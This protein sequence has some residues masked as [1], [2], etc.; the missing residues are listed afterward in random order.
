[1]KTKLNFSSIF[2][3]YFLIT[4]Y[5]CTINSQ[6]YTEESNPADFRIKNVNHIYHHATMVEKIKDSEITYFL[7]Y[8]HPDSENSKQGIKFLR[9]IVPKLEYLAEILLVNCQLSDYAER[10]VCIKPS[11]VKDGFPRMVVLIPPKVKINPYTKKPNSYVEKKYTEQEV[12]PKSIY[13][14]ITDNIPDFSIHL[15]N[16]N[17]DEFLNDYEY[18][19][20]ILF[21]DKETT[22]LLYRGLSGYYYDRVKFG[23]VKSDQKDINSRFQ[24]RQ[25][26]T[27]L[28]YNVID[29]GLILFNPS[30]DIYNGSTEAKSLVEAL[31]YT[32]LSEKKYIK[33]K[34]NE[35]KEEP[36]TDKPEAAKK[37]F[38]IKNLSSELIE[39]YISRSLS[40]PMIIIL[41]NKK[42]VN[43][44]VVEFAKKIAGFVAFLN[45]DCQD[46]ST[47]EFVE[48]KMKAKC[49]EGNKNH[50][51]YFLSDEVE[52]KEIKVEEVLKKSRQLEKYSYKELE[53]LMI[54]K[55]NS[56]VREIISQDYDSAKREVV[57]EGK[58]IF[59][60]LYEDVS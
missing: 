11:E 36:K 35:K 50:Y 18:N 54:K 1:M 52:E 25:Y 47:K 19:K 15:N 31:S 56:T 24:I 46:K 9:E 34:S 6:E 57:E 51:Y 37:Y 60:Y 44:G 45:I 58:T 13:K 49:P 48:D 12:S 20:L 29:E 2:K 38:G 27:L 53:K 30:I 33:E 32:A 41:R 39:H 21:T 22:P 42:T 5:F 7:F 3:L 23:L 28:F 26:P 14:F 17:I 8:Y 43:K 4:S 16:E 59:V 40:R 55:F 10:S